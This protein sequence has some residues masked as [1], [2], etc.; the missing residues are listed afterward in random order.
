V[1]QL[2]GIVKALATGTE[3]DQGENEKLTVQG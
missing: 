3:Y 1:V 2:A